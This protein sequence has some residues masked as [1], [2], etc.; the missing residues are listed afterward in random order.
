MTIVTYSTVLI[1]SYYAL[2]IKDAQCWSAGSVSAERVGLRE[3]GQGKV[4]AQTEMTIWCV[5]GVCTLKVV[6]SEKI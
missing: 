2:C 4:G 5:T 6:S 1:M 3:V